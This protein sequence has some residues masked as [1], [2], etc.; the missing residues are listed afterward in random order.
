MKIKLDA[1]APKGT[2]AT[3]P[4]AAVDHG[5]FGNFL[6]RVFRVDSRLKMFSAV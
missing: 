3:C 4:G 2:L 5:S 1:L 6:I